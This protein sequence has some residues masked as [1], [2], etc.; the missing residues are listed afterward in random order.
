MLHADVVAAATGIGGSEEHRFDYRQL[1]PTDNENLWSAIYYDSSILPPGRI[2]SPTFEFLVFAMRP[3]AAIT[4]G[5]QACSQIDTSY[6]AGGSGDV[7]GPSIGR[8]M[9]WLNWA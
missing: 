1:L 9:W 3:S 7:G 6:P 2:T 8:Y 4:P 5:R